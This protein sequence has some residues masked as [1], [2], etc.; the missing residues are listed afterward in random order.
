MLALISKHAAVVVTSF[1]RLIFVI[2][3]TRVVCDLA[4]DFNELLIIK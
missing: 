4:V 3:T 2:Q 1:N